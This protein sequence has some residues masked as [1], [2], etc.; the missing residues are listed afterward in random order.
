VDAVSRSFGVPENEIF[1]GS[2]RGRGLIARQ[3]VYVIAAELC[4]LTASEVAKAA[5]SQSRS[6]VT[7]AR[8]AIQKRA[9]LDPDLARRMEWV[10][11]ELQ[12]RQVNPRGQL[13]ALI[14]EAWRTSPEEVLATVARSLSIPVDRLRRPI[15]TYNDAR[16][17]ATA[18]YVLATVR[19][20]S[21]AEIQRAVGGSK[22]RISE[23]IRDI[24]REM[25][26]N[27]GYGAR[28]AAIVAEL[29]GDVRHRRRALTKVGETASESGNTLEA[30][31]V[32]DAVRG[33]LASMVQTQRRRRGLTVEKLASYSASS[34]SSIQRLEDGKLCTI[35]TLAKVAAA[36]DCEVTITLRPRKTAVHAARDLTLMERR[37]LRAYR[38]QKTLA[39]TADLL[40]IALGTVK[41]HATSIRTKL[42]ATSIEE[43]LNLAIARDVLR[44]RPANDAKRVLELIAARS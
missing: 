30:A 20:A 25:A 36:L 18:M 22:A 7:R 19:D 5:G 16:A 12:G 8:E 6:V 28:V 11:A 35:T 23:S 9:L 33:E 38:R 3:V 31:A 14:D 4:G 27:P 29:G 1:H 2:D 39:K 43:A 15:S 10:R 42:G 21:P 34:A 17:R 40:K 41:V 26:R 32:L 37:V 24:K 44:E 13:A